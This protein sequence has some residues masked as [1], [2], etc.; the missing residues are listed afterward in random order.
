MGKL[1]VR[2]LPWIA[3]C[4]LTVVLVVSGH[5]QSAPAVIGI[6]GTLA[7]DVSW[8]RTT[9]PSNGLEY[10]VGRFGGRAA[11][12]L[13]PRLYVG[14]GVSSWQFDAGPPPGFV[15]PPNEYDAVVTAVVFSAYGQLYPLG[16]TGTFIRGGVGYAKTRRYAPDFEFLESYNVSHLAIA[17]GVGADVT[18][19][20]HLAITIS[21]DYTSLLGAAGYRQAKSALLMGVGLTLR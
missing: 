10:A 4:F 5:A 2:S 19:R 1:V 15:V 3:V 14:V 6:Q 17:G 21:A 13:V 12:R 9:T 20:P 7:Y 8:V 16:T 11:M 18:L